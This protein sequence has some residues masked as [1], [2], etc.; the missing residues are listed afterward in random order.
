MRKL[1][2][3]GLAAATTVLIGSATF[4]QGSADTFRDRA[5]DGAKVHVSGFVCPARIGPFERDAVGEYDPEHNEDFCAYGARDGVYGTITLNPLNGG[6][7]PKAA[8]ADDFS[9][10]DATGGKRLFEK[11]V[12]L[13]GSQLSIYTR[14]Y[15]TARAEA[16]E[17][18]ILF[19]GAAVK[20]WV[21]QTT[22]EYADPRDA[23]AE[24]EFLNAVYAAAE[25]Q[26]GAP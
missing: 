19:A 10:Q 9:E 1:F 7:D 11:Q 18:R 3:F 2:A 6:Y 17:Y 16:L 14:T 26:I 22:V 15:R 12:R 5:D 25:K 24:A 21:V 8:F 23:A 4:A 20:N 13:Q